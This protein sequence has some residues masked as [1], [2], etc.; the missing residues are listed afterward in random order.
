MSR[1]ME[2]LVVSNYRTEMMYGWT[3]GRG[4]IAQEWD[5][6]RED[7]R[8]NTWERGHS[9]RTRSGRGWCTAERM[10]EGSQHENEIWTGMMYGWTHGRGV[11]AWERDPEGDDVRLNAWER[12]HSMRTRSGRGWCTAER[13][14]EGSQHENEIRTGM[15]HGWTHGRGVI[16]RAR[17]PDGDDVQLNAWERS[18]SMRTRS[19]RGWCMAER[20]GEGSQHENEIWTGM[21]Y[22]WTHGRGVIAQERVQFQFPLKVRSH[23]TIV[24]V[25]PRSTLIIT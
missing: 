5:P 11:T 19:G 9:M 1:D 23:L 16:A 13:M 18:H 3:H 22:G 17:D 14:G 21:M 10:G 15:M 2:K 4:V 12:G 20:M 25:E 24:L 8:L 6:D 7:V